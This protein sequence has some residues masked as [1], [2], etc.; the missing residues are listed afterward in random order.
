MDFFMEYKHYKYLIEALN[1][2]VTEICNFSVHSYFIIHSCISQ[3][4]SSGFWT[5]VKLEFG[6]D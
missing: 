6:V 5:G 3:T 4:G 2:L 1:L